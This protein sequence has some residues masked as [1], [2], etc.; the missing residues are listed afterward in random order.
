[1]Y[2]IIMGIFNNNSTFVRSIIH[3]KC[4]YLLKKC[5]VGGLYVKRALGFQ[6]NH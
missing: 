3:F 1:M 2:D 5:W 6:T 4:R